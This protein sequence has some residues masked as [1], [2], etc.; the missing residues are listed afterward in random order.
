M[1]APSSLS[2]RVEEQEARGRIVA[3]GEA[4]EAELTF[5]KAG[6]SRIIADHTLVPDAMGGQGVGTELVRRLH[7][8][9]LEHGVKAVALCPFVKAKMAKHP[10]WQ[11]VLDR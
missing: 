3:E 6:T 11:D 9:A 1:M 4:G 2:Y 5:S 8:Y 7:D 10:E